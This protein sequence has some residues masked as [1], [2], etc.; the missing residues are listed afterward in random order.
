MANNA[1]VAVTVGSLRILASGYIWVAGCI[2][3]NPSAGHSWASCDHNG[4]D[5]TKDTKGV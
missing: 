2:L 3:L 4:G 1:R 5:L